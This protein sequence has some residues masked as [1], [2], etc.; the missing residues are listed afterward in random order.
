MLGQLLRDY[1]GKTWSLRS[2]SK[3]L[4]QHGVSLDH[5]VL[6]R[7]EKG[8]R[9][10]RVHELDAIALVLR[11]TDEQRLRLV[12]ATRSDTPAPEAS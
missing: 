2:L 5:S 8:E 4:E 10:L 6:W 11:L 1:R 9:D 12:S 3:A 7:I